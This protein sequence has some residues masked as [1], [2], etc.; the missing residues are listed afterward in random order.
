MNDLA[1]KFHTLSVQ[2]IGLA[3]MTIYMRRP[4]VIL[5]VSRASHVFCLAVASPHATAEQ[6]KT[7]TGQL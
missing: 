1:M 4:N 3:Q 6:L 7:K 2:Y 5:P